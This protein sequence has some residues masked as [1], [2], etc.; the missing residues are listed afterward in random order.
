[1]PKKLFIQTFFPKKDVAK[2]LRIYRRHHT[3]SLLRYARLMAY[4]QKLL[5]FLKKNDRIIAIASNRPKYFTGIILKKLKIKRYI[6]AVAC[7]GE[8]RNKKPSPW[9]LNAVIK[10]FGIAMT[11]Q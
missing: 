4:A 9:L 11:K 7:A 8:L 2:A 3:R 5:Y 1:M 10:R 6:D